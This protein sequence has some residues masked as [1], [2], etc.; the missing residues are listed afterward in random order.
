MSIWKE[1]AELVYGAEHTFLSAI[2]Y[3]VWFLKYLLPLGNA[4]CKSLY[5]IGCYTLSTLKSVQVGGAPF[6]SCASCYGCYVFVMGILLHRFV[7]LLCYGYWE[8]I[9]N[10]LRRIIG[11]RKWTKMY[12]RFWDW[13]TNENRGKQ[14]RIL[15]WTG[16]GKADV[17]LW[18]LKCMFAW[19]YAHMCIY[20]YM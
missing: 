10:F 11:L 20:I 15:W 3:L 13:Y 2:S 5:K 12:R 14:E 18:F 8:E 17:I 16:I 9:R 4:H 19:L 1:S 7:R 6:G